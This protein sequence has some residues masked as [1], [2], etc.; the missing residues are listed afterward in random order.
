MSCYLKHFISPLVYFFPNAPTRDTDVL[1]VGFILSRD[2]GC[3]QIFNDSKS[4]A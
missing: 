2:E 4:V 3:G 1:P